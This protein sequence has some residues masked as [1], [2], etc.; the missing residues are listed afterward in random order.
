MNVEITLM[1][2]DD[3]PAVREIYAEGIATKNA[4][5]ETT[6]PEWERWDAGHLQSCR[7][8]ARLNGQIVG[9][10]ALSPVSSRQVYA[11][12]AEESI[13]ITS[14]ARGQGVGK[15]LLLALVDASEQAGIWTL[16]TGIFPENKVSIHLH[17]ACGFRVLGMREKIGQMDGVWR[18][19]A[20]LERRSKVVGV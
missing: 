10:A 20:F 7:L 16:Q 14:A 1:Q 5:F 3:W 15:Q 2:A 13:Y 19:V 4:T 17:E 9:W 11:G 8:V 18:D 6:A 12:V